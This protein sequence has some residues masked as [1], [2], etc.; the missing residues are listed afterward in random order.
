[1]YSFHSSLEEKNQLLYTLTRFGIETTVDRSKKKDRIR[2]WIQ[3]SA[4]VEENEDEESAS[5][6]EEIEKL[7]E[8]DEDN[9]NMEGRHFPPERRS[10]VKLAKSSPERPVTSSGGRIKSKS[11]NEKNCRPEKEKLKR[12]KSSHR[13]PSLRNL[14]RRNPF[15]PQVASEMQ[16]FARF[17]SFPNGDPNLG[18]NKNNLLQPL[19]IMQNSDGFKNNDLSLGQ[20]SSSG[21]TNSVDYSDSP[22]IVDVNPGYYLQQNSHVPLMKNHP[23]QVAA[24][25][26]TI[27]QNDSSLAV[28]TEINK[29]II[30]NNSLTMPIASHLVMQSFNA[31]QAINTVSASQNNNSST[32]RKDKINPSS[33]VYG[34][35]AYEH[36]GVAQGT[37]VAVVKTEPS[38]TTSTR[39]QHR[40]RGSSS[41]S[42]SVSN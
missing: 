38:T 1:M 5:I 27:F 8:T 35:D 19:R 17:A 40:A 29:Q 12:S 33:Q 21:G 32:V 24:V 9:N 6:L 31:I 30:N 28:A 41:G 20:G 10:S 18:I 13:P 34:K 39:Q 3:A 7:N 2:E 15:A 16:T 25:V 37:T 42:R 22:K 11:M 36:Y 23:G 14:E 4:I 26:T